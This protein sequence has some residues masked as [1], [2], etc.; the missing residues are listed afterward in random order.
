MKSLRQKKFGVCCYC[1]QKTKFYKRSHKECHNKFML[2]NNKIL[3]L[4]DL[5]LKGRDVDDIERAIKKLMDNPHA[6][7][8]SKVTN[9]RGSFNH[10]R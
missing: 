4:T 9:H 8:G 1:G 5:M 6:K 3:S 2:G 7:H 10:G